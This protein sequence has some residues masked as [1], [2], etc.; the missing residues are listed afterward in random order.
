MRVSSR[1]IR[2]ARAAVIGAMLA[3]GQPTRRVARHSGDDV[4]NVLGVDFLTSE[5]PKAPPRPR[6]S[7]EYF[8]GNGARER[9]RRLRQI[10]RRRA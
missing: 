9:E 1:P 6:K 3:L 8:A 7:A 5:Q 10:A 4:S 2:F